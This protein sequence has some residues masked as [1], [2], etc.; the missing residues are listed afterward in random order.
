MGFSMP[1]SNLPSARTGDEPSKDHRQELLDK[2]KHLAPPENSRDE[3]TTTV[4]WDASWD[5][6]WNATWDATWDAS[7]HAYA[8]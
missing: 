7:W 1:Q 4:V 8:P 2:L 6:S 5:A 3:D